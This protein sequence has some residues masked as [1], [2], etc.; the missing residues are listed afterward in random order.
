MIRHQLAEDVDTAFQT[1][2]AQLLTQFVCGYRDI[3]LRDATGLGHGQ[4]IARHAHPE[5]R[6]QWVPR[7]RAGELA[8]IAVTEPH[9]GSRVAQTRTHAVPAPDGTWFVTGRK[10]WISRL[11]EAAVFVVF[12]RDPTGQLAAAV[13]DA[14]G[15]GLRRELIQPSGLAGWSWGTLDLHKVPVR[16]K[17]VLDGEGM[18][19]LR[20]HLAGY[21]PLVTATALGGAAAIFDTVTTT[22]A[23]RHT[24]GEPPRPRDSTLVTL[25]R[26]HAQ[27]VAALL[28]AAVATQL[29]E[30]GDPRAEL[31]SAAMKAHGIDTANHALSELAPLLG[32]AGFRADSQTAKT[33]EDLCGLLYAD[34]IHDS[35]YRAAGKHHTA[36]QDA[37]VP[38]PRVTSEPRPITA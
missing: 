7:L 32:A 37:D 16:P 14:A 11:T 3:D 33:R 38:A 34:G 30:A 36:L 8:G 18:A 35:L 27:L 15:P 1:A 6:R 10:T 20:Q 2:M 28:G 22:L 29:A 19:L 25:G 31:C 13:I 5:T 17:D 24:S 4:L 23:T 9:G 21:R 26:T 12:F